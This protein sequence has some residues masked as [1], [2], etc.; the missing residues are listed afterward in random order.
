MNRMPRKGENIHK[1]KDGRWEAR[2]IKGYDSA[3][4]VIYGYIFGKSY[5]E[6]KRK[7]RE[8]ATLLPTLSVLPTLPTL[9]TSAN[10]QN[11]PTVGALGTSG[12]CGGLFPITQIVQIGGNISNCYKAN[13]DIS[14]VLVISGSGAAGCNAVVTDDAGTVHSACSARSTS[15]PS[16][17]LLSDLALQWLE[18]LISI[19]KKSTVVK[20]AGQLKNYI[21]P[22]FGDKR[23]DCVTTTDLMDFS[24]Y[25]LHSGRKDGKNNGH[26]S[27]RT[28]VN[29]LAEMKSMKNRSL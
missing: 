28:V 16:S 1:R 13:H 23:I 24:R 27:P 5:L 12:T 25:L 29:I 15:S 19:R 4:K 3:G 26:L 18:S 9:P 6:V 22:A 2:Y 7:R 10:L 21:L 8:S 11:L 20:Y 14:N 17:P